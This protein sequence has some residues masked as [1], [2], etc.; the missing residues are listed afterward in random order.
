DSEGLEVPPKS[1]RFRRD[2]PKRRILGLRPMVLRLTR[3][4]KRCSPGWPDCEA[5]AL[6]WQSG[7]SFRRERGNAFSDAGSSAPIGSTA[8][9][10]MRLL[11]PRPHPRVIADTRERRRTVEHVLR[12]G[13]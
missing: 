8:F 13:D 6:V 1:L 10:S 7:L 12:R 11:K 4:S 9:P 5:L 2:A 3:R